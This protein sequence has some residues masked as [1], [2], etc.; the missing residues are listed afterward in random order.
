MYLNNL[1]DIVGVRELSLKGESGVSECVQILIGTPRPFPDSTG[2]YCPFQIVGLG[3][4]EIKY[5]AG[6]DAIQTLQLV[7]PMIVITLRS[8][9]EKIEGGLRWEAG[10]E[11]DLGFPEMP[12]S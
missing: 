6:I 3:S 7:M 10:E 4:A 12:N 11:S 5:A 1:G 8:L 9:S 2:Y